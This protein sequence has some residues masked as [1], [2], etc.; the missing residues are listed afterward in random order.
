[1]W[2]ESKLIWLGIGAVFI[3]VF[4]FL[5]LAGI[6]LPDPIALPFFLAFTL[7]FGYQT[8]WHGFQSLIHLNFKS[9]NALMLIAVSGAFYLKEYP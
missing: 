7:I 6:R 1:M 2:K 5:S 8:L 3:A 9:I 4:E